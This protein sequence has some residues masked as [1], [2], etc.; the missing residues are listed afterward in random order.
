[1]T[2]RASNRQLANNSVIYLNDIMPFAVTLT[3]HQRDP[4]PLTDTQ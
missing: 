4:L 3:L 2:L 1:M